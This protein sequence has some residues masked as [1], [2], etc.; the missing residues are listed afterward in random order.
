MPVADFDFD[1][2]DAPEK[3]AREIITEADVAE[4]FQ[5]GELNKGDAAKALK[6][7]TGAHHSSCYRALEPGGRFARHLRFEKG[8]LT[9]K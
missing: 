4:I 8:K 5:N 6:S 2:F 9:W 3:D 7:N 1:A